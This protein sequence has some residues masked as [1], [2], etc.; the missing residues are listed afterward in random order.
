MI[1]QL[2]PNA[3][4]TYRERT[5]TMVVAYRIRR[6]RNSSLSALIKTGVRSLSSRAST[7]SPAQGGGDPLLN[8]FL[9]VGVHRQAQHFGCQ[10][11]RDRQTVS[12]YGVS[13]ISGLLVQRLWLV[14]RGWYAPP[15]QFRCRPVSVLALGQTYR[16]LSPDAGETSR[17]H[18]H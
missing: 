6:D 8:L 4:P 11:I 5:S 1:A 14:H 13:V 7:Q 17:H 12:G 3:V 2:K 18:W 16:I 10:P 15:L 9:Q